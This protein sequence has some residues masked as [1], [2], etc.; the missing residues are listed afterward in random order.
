MVRAKDFRGKSRC[1]EFLWLKS[2]HPLM[3][4][5][6]DRKQRQPPLRYTNLMQNCNFRW[7]RECNACKHL[8]LP[9]CQPTHLLEQQT[10]TTPAHGCRSASEHQEFS[11]CNRDD[12]FIFH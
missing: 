4:S 6:P 10:A 3:V 5:L 11:G 2:L 8:R 1:I 7:R 12:F 9:L